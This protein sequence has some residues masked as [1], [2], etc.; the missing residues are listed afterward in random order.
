MFKISVEGVRKIIK[1]S[2]EV[3]TLIDKPRSG[4]PRVTTA[5]DDRRIVRQYIINPKIVIR[6]IREQLYEAG[7]SVSETTIRRRLH[8]GKLRG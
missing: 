6:E 3:S 7:T 8:D 2:R 4:R 1:K 5:S